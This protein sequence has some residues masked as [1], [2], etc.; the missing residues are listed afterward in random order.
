MRRAISC[1]MSV[2]G[3]GVM[4]L[5]TMVSLPGSG[6]VTPQSEP[7]VVV[8]VEAAVDEWALP[9]TPPESADLAIEQYA[10]DTVLIE[11]R[12]Q[13]LFPFL[14]LD[15][16]FLE[17]S[18]TA[19]EANRR[20][21]TNPFAP[22]VLAVERPPLVMSDAEAGRVVD[23]SWSR[24]RRWPAF[25]EIATLLDRFDPNGGHLPGVLRDYVDRNVLQPFCDGRSIE[26]RFWASMEIAAEHADFLRFMREQVGR[27]ALTRAGTELLFL[28]DKLAV[29]N[30]DALLLLIET[31]PDRDLPSTAAARGEA[32][33][34]VRVLQ[35]E[36]IDRLHALGLRSIPAV[37]AAYD[38]VRLRIL[39]AVVERSPDGYGVADARF[40]AG[41]VAFGAGDVSEAVRWWQ[42][43]TPEPDGTYFRDAMRILQL[44][45]SPGALN[46]RDVREVLRAVHGRWRVASIYRLREFGHAC[47]TY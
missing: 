28:L 32:L 1:A 29:A 46:L 9:E 18:G 35:Y 15:L 3:H 16:S 33:A 22:D 26:P 47:G 41:G 40:L 19:F 4:L 11:S 42:D 25:A 20:R 39:S 17:S 30:R 43:M 6:Q 7:Q 13:H 24:R 8:S 2:L 5:L 23:R 31:N 37:R 10:F 27:G 36:H 45:G 34:L 14:S 21:L 38:D 12:R 44:L